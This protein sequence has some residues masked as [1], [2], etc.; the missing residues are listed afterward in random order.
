ME[1]QKAESDKKIKQH[2]SDSKVNKM[3]R[4]GAGKRWRNAE[5]ERTSL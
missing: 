3:A 2:A 4:D 5:K 1:N